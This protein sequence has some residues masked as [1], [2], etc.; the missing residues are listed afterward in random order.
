MDGECGIC[1]HS[2]SS[3]F[4]VGFFRC[5]F[6]FCA[7]S[8]LVLGLGYAF[9]KACFLVFASFSLLFRSRVEA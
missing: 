2:L 9:E 1:Y 5:C 4:E 7:L 6:W 8:A 3:F